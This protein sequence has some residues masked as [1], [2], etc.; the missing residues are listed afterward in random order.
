MRFYHFPPAAEERK[1]DD[2]IRGSDKPN[3]GKSSIVNQLL[4]KKGS[5][6]AIFRHN[7]GCR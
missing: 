5:L 2:V 4:G 3:V 1:D 6:S 7:P